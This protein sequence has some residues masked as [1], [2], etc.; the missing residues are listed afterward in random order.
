[1]ANYVWVIETMDNQGSSTVH[2]VVKDDDSRA[3]RV[4]S[5]LS[6]W[7]SAPDEEW[8]DLI[9]WDDPDD[10]NYASVPARWFR[11]SWSMTRMEV[12]G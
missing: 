3:Q 8:A 6:G 12:Q 5:D 4:L 9:E 1:M 10:R 7:G 11:V 2:A